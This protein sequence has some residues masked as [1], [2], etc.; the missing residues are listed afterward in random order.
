L[1]EAAPHAARIAVRGDGLVAVVCSGVA[2]GWRLPAVTAVLSLVP[3]LLGFANIRSAAVGLLCALAAWVLSLDE[4]REERPIFAGLFVVAFAVRSLALM[5]FTVWLAPSGGPY[6]S[7]DGI[8]YWKAATALS[9][10]TYDLSAGAIKAF[11]SYDVASYYYFGGLAWLFGGQLFAVQLTN[12]GVGA[13]AAPL[14]FSIVRRLSLPY[15]LAIG[16]VVAIHPSLTFLTSNNLLKDPSVMTASL[17]VTWAGVRIVGDRVASR[18][19]ALYVAAAVPAYAYLRFGRFYTAAF[20]AL[21]FTAAAIALPVLEAARR[22]WSGAASR[23]PMA[24]SWRTPAPPV[25]GLL[26]LLALFGGVE[27]AAV[28]AGWPPGPVQARSLIGHVENAPMMRDYAPGLL[29]TPGLLPAEAHGDSPGARLAAASL[30]RFTDTVRRLYGPFVWIV[31]DDWDP[32]ALVAADYFLYPGMLLWYGLLPLL[33]A[34]L[35]LSAIRLARGT[36]Q[37]I[38]VLALLLFS[39]TYM[40]QFLMINL[41]HRQRDDLLP[42]LLVFAGVGLARAPRWRYWTLAYTLYWGGIVVMAVLHLA[43]RARLAS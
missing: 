3:V 19:L 20:L 23:G 9:A 30:R 40:A 35:G 17:L 37:R 33:V 31:P 34:G 26:A 6:L 1:I 22:R 14:A 16:F 10:G 43:L 25:A 24:A 29:S 15:A 2:A 7:P 39:L 13:L 41:S 12:A 18:R 28:A 4:T 27:A 8:G 42:F 38:A 36:E 5:A 11:G 21:S 32:R